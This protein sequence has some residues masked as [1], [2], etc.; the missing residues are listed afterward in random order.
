MLPTQHL[1]S[2]LLAGLVLSLSVGGCA[3]WHSYDAGPGLGAGQPLPYFLRA[4]RG[5]GSRTVLSAPFVQADTLYGRVGRDRVG[6]HVGEI[7]HLERQR[8][9]PGRTAALVVGVPVVGL[10]AAYVILCGIRDCTPVY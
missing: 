8:V 2:R 10:G 3:T 4:T 1:R 5:D 6:V 9:N 7:V